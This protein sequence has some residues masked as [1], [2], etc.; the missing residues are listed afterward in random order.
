M[1]RA[2]RRFVARRVVGMLARSADAGRR[3]LRSPAEAPSPATPAVA[4]SP[5][6]SGLVLDGGAWA[7]GAQVATSTA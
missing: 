3:R 1:Q 4:Y 2:F 5:A 6:G 7:R